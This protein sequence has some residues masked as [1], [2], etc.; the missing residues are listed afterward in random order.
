MWDQRFNVPEYI[1]G[2]KP[3]DFLVEAANHIPKGR[4][5][6]LADG[7]G[8]N[9]VYLARQGF[10][11]TS[12]DQSNVGL[13]KAQALASAH[14]VSIE[15]VHADLAD[16]PIE[17]GDWAGIISIFCHL[18]PSL[19]SDVHKRAVNGLAS[20]G[21]FI[22]EA[23]T[24]QQLQFKTGGP[25]SVDLLMDLSTL[26]Q[27]LSGLQIKHGKEIQRQIE[28]GTYHNGLSSVVQIMALKA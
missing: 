25:Q 8:R 6:C 12:V 19:R 22:L 28:E 17:K 15:T 14:G 16:Y 21:C 4:V 11:V 26:Q 23:Y 3:N 27:E 5:L 7:E 24:P 10:A 1:Y 2:T 9:G 13:K 18:P 20:G